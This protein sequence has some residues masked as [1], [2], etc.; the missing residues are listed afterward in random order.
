MVPHRA[1]P[2]QREIEG[3]RHPGE[4]MPVRLLSRSQ[5]PGEGF[6]SQAL[7]NMGILS[8]VAVIVIIY[9][10]V[11]IDGIV[12][13]Q[14][15]HREKQ[16]HNRIALLRRRKNNGRFSRRHSCSCGRQYEDLITEGTDNTGEETGKTRG[17]TIVDLLD[18]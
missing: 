8:D 9:K 10:R 16:T 7:T 4:R 13:S 3:V 2:K 6:S 17:T 11:P 15:E 12:E 5:R 18:R 1:Q 14:R